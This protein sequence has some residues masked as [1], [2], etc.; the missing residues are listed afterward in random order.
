MITLGGSSCDNIVSKSSA[1]RNV[2]DHLGRE[3]LWLH[4]LEGLLGPNVGD[5]FG[6]ELLRLHYLGELLVLAEVALGSSS[7]GCIV[8][9]S[10]RGRIVGDHIGREL[11]R[12]HRLGEM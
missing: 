7:C 11:L 6:R 8:S 3:L 2:G 1:G 10:C 5:H 4:R 12:Q 9:R